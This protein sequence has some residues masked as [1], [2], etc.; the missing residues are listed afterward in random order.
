MVVGCCKVFDR[1]CYACGLGVAVSPSL[2]TAVASA[3]ISFSSLLLINNWK[4]IIFL[5]VV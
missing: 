5:S 2:I 3:N 1:A 4:M